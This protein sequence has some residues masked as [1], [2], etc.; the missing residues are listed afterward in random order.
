MSNSVIGRIH[1]ADVQDFRVGRQSLI[2]S[3]IRVLTVRDLLLTM[4]AGL[5]GGLD[6]LYVKEVLGADAVIL[7]LIASIWSATFLFF[8]L[9]G[10]WLSDHCDRKS[11]VIID[12]KWEEQPRR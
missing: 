11:E 5:T 4:I 6:A 12:V 7:G 8:I 9:F 10:G 2:K 1:F 3:N